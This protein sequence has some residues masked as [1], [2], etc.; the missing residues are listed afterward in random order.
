MSTTEKNKNEKLLKA[1]K[2]LKSFEQEF[3]QNEQIWKDLEERNRKI[4]SE[5][6]Q[7]N[8]TI[9]LLESNIQQNLHVT[10]HAVLRYIE[11]KYKLP[12]ENIKNEILDQLKLHNV[13]GETENFMGFVI[14]NNSV[15]TY[16]D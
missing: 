5:I 10:D 2:K 7:L 11:R 16:L 14:R 15:I 4:R 13:L 6:K 1:K 3:K 12:I 9:N 8:N